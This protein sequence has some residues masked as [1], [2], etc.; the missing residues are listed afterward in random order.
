M[1]VSNC[2][3]GYGWPA[4][5]NGPRYRAGVGCFLDPSGHRLRWYG[6]PSKSRSPFWNWSA[7][8]PDTRA[9]SRAGFPLIRTWR[10]PVGKQ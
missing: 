8:Q 6:V 1:S 2:T 10:L 5:S 7:K 3:C 9:V 4:A